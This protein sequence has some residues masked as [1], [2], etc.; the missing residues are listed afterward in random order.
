ML[1]VTGSGQPDGPHRRDARAGRDGHAAASPR[2]GHPV[3]NM[4]VSAEAD[5]ADGTDW[6]DGASTGPDGTYAI[7]GLPAIA[8]KVHFRGCGDDSQYVEQW[9]DHAATNESAKALTLAP[10]STRTGIDAAARRRRFRSAAPS[11]TA[12]ATRC[13]ASARRRRRARSSAASARTNDQGRYTINVA[14]PGSYVV[15]FVDCSGSHRYAGQWWNNQ[16]RRPRAHSPSR[17]RTVRS[18][19]TSTRSWR[20]VPPARS[21][22]RSSTSTARP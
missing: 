8:L 14:K 22:G 12:P 4:C 13:R 19:S 10:G 2:P 15:Q 20:G 21:P 9:W 1:T 17:S 7:S 6:I 16:P 5:T 11:P 18:S 3:G